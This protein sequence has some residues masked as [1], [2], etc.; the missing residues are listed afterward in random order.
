LNETPPIVTSAFSYGPRILVPAP[1]VDTYKES[2]S[3]SAY[4][5]QI[6]AIPE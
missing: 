3:W 1:A 2:A 4:A 5:S 6:R